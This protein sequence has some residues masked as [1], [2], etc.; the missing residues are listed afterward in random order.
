MKSL[1]PVQGVGASQVWRQGQFDLMVTNILVR[2]LNREE[3][4][5]SKEFPA[6]PIPQSK[7]RVRS[8]LQLGQPFWRLCGVC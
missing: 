8:S 4:V 2:G 3:V 1:K 6:V 7:T 5:S